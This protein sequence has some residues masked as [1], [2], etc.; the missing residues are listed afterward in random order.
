MFGT[1]RVLHILIGAACSFIV[2][3]SGCKDNLPKTAPVKGSITYQGKAV[4]QGSVMFQ[5]DDGPAATAPIKDGQYVLKTFR[6]GDGAILG[7]HKVTV[8]SL[9]DQ[10]GRLPE[11]RSPLPR[12]LVPLE[13]SFADKSG[14]S[15]KVED[16]HNIIDFHMK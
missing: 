13:F 14:L 11:D 12:P 10:S 16:K 9:E 7:N 3:M 15:A 2:A 4:A 1:R 8:I 6:D 5:P